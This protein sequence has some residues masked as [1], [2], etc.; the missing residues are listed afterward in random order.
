MGFPLPPSK[1]FLI[2][3]Q[4]MPP[5]KKFKTDLFA[6]VTSKPVPYVTQR[7]CNWEGKPTSFVGP[8]PAPRQVAALQVDASPSMLQLV[9][10]LVETFTF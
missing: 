4:G 9:A 8:V 1:L 2:L 7:W 6:S 3:F 10:K 5:Y